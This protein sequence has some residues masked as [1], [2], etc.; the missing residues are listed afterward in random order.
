MK[1]SKTLTL[2]LAA[3]V[4]FA[5]QVAPSFAAPKYNWIEVESFQDDG[6][7]I[8]DYILSWLD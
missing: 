7:S 5:A 2:A 8:W 4:I 6:G 1:S 3:A